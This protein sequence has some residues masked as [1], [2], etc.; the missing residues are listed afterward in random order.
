MST[1]INKSTQVRTRMS[2]PEAK[3]IALTELARRRQ[4]LGNLTRDQEISLEN[5]MMVAVT[6]VSEEAGKVLESLPI[7]VGAS[8]RGRPN[9]A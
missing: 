3:E 1:G 7:V 4:R 9:V 2:L 8:L 5:L 6:R